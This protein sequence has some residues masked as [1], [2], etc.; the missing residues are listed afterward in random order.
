MVR[1]IMKM[2]GVRKNIIAVNTGLINV[3]WMR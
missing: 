3:V 1:L 2:I